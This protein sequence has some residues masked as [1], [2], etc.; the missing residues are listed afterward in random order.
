MKKVLLQSNSEKANE[1]IIKL[2]NFIFKLNELPGLFKVLD[3]G[4]FDNQTAITIL[5]DCGK[6]AVSQFKNSILADAESS[7]SKNKNYLDSL[8]K[9]QKPVIDKFLNDV[10][11]LLKSN[12]G[13]D[14]A[15]YDYDEGIGY[16]IS[17][18]TKAEIT[19]SAKDYLTNAREIDLYN[20]TNDYC[21]AL[22]KLNLKVKELTGKDFIIEGS[23]GFDHK[24]FPRNRIDGI[25]YLLRN[26]LNKHGDKSF[27]DSSAFIKFKKEFV[28]Q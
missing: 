5:N 2:E 1:V 13:I 24:G 11:E 23:N 17:D 14:L 21:D 7:G 20:I 27:V 6:T 3:L 15:K 18:R 12:T 22:N 4:K 10:S 28:S 16:F 9:L 26:L 25:K 8:I 19:E